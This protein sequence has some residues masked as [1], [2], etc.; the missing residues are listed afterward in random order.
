MK[1]TI[2]VIILLAIHYV[3]KAEQLLQ[4]QGIHHDIILVPRQISSDCGMAIELSSEDVDRVE[5]L[6]VAARLE[7]VG[8]YQRDNDQTFHVLK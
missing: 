7:I 3:L 6:L 4:E 5:G 2:C 8:I 1:E